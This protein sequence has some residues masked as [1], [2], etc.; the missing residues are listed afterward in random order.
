MKDAGE[1]DV[2]GKGKAFDQLALEDVAAQR[3]GTGFEHRPEGPARISGAQS[4]QG[5]ADRGGMVGEIVD[6]GDAVDFCAHF[7]PAS[8]AAKRCQRFGNRFRGNSLPRGQRRRGGRVQGIVLASHRQRQF[9]PLFALA[10][11]APVADAVLEA[12]I[13]Q[14]PG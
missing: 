13:G 10:Q 7:E 6:D 11:H 14:A 5:F 12:Q 4:T 2:V 8:H 1:D 9:S 3:V